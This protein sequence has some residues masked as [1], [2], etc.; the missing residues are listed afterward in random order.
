MQPHPIQ[1]DLILI[2]GGHSHAIVL[3]Q[4]G[5]NP[6]PGVRLTLITD[7]SHTPY[8]GMLPGYIAGAYTFDECHIDLRP[9]CEFAQGQ[10]IV[11]RAIGLDLKE[12]RVLFADRPPIAF[13]VVS[14]DIGSTPAAVTIPGA[15][16]YAI[17]VKPISQ[18]LQRWDRVVDRITKQSDS[19]IRIAV[20]GGGAGGVE[21]TLGLQ[22]RLR[23]IQKDRGQQESGQ[24]IE[25]HLFH[26]GDRLIPERH[27]H[28]GR[29]IEQIMRQR[30]IHLHLNET[31]CKISAPG[32]Q[33]PPEIQSPP[34]LGDLGGI[35]D[36]RDV[37]HIHCE[38]GL[39]LPIDE[40]FWVTQASAAPW[41]AESGLQTDDRGFLL[42]DNMLRSISHP[43]VFAAGDVASMVNYPRPKA[44][45]FAVRQGKPLADNLRRVLQGE[46]PQPF[47]PQKEFLI[48][49]GTGDFPESNFSEG[50]QSQR[51]AIASRG[52]LSFG[53]HPIFWKWKDSI[54]RKFMQKFSDLKPM[55]AMNSKPSPTPD[56]PLPMHCAGCGSKVGSSV[57]QR[58]LSRIDQS[59]IADRPDI[60]L[61]LN[62]PDDAAV[63]TV[64][65]GQVMVQTVDYFRSLLSDPFIFGQIAA[66]HALSDL[67]A[68]GAMP[69][70]AMAIVTLPYSSASKQEE[71]LYQVLSGAMQI[72]SQ[73]NAA[74]IGGHTIEGA[75]LAFGLSCNGLATADQLW[76]K[77]GMQPGQ[78]LILTKPLGTGTLF[79]ANMQLRAKGRWIEGAIASM[80]QS[81]QFAIDPLFCWD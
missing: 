66:N 49:V 44:G 63:V 40:I 17:P 13:D 73:A 31:V 42:V 45:V 54:D 77:G 46:D 36:L 74:L 81:N 64:P 26:K 65:S 5:M 80:Q 1:K 69:Q 24:Q 21:L 37:K 79:A 27:P 6:I 30:G 50:K 34:E 61:G 33:S 25:L 12:N 52:N 72:L 51:S 8:S 4:L 10:M 9:L 19:P 57:L 55:M 18:F 58:A 22:A 14:I 41:L 68:M 48:L 23:Q 15:A 35:K 11:D 47:K 20:V 71:T 3:K 29:Q 62:A 38:S 59:H 16:E 67:F 60:L 39:T 56:S 7:V 28:L 43:Q 76:K 75:E 70:S 53:P 32:T 2:G 78:S